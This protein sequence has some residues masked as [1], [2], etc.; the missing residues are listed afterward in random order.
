M[1]RFF[2]LLACGPLA[3]IALASASDASAQ[4]RSKHTVTEY[5]LRR[6][7]V[8]APEQLQTT[9]G[10]ARNAAAVAAALGTPEPQAVVV[11]P[12]HPWKRLATLPAVAVIHDISFSSDLVGYVV[13]ERGLVFKT[14]DGGYHWNTALFSDSSDYWYGV[15]AASANDI[16]ITGFYDSYDRV[17]HAPIFRALAR[18]SHDAGATW[19]DSIV[20][21]TDDWAIRGRFPDGVHGVVLGENLNGTD[22]PAFVTSNGGAI[23]TDW[24]RVGT[25]NTGWFGTQFSAHANGHVRASGTNYCESFDFGAHWSCGPQ[26]D[27]VYDGETFFLDELHGWVASGSTSPTEEGWIRKTDDGGAHWSARTLDGPWPIRELLFID[28][29]TGWAVGG[30]AFGGIGGIY[31]T[32]DGGTNWSLDVDTGAE[33]SSCSKADTM[34]YCAGYDRS[35]NGYIYALNLDQVFVD[36][37]ETP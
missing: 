37:F 31:S 19:S 21:R 33:M 13:A 1:Y 25:T 2:I 14:I 3:T 17:K 9:A 29:T 7:P 34:V 24:S 6:V 11:G 23:A 32:S 30:D 12:H 15:Q 22:T 28:A 26:I 10:A 18:W 8:T 20:I 16:V 36:G 35:F 27:P 5:V 4:S